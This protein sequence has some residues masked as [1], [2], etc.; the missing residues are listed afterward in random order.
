[1]SQIEQLLKYQQEDEKL[2]KLEHETANSEERKRFVQ[3][4][5]FLTKA[6]EQL[7]RLETK[8]ADL[9]SLLG[10]LNKSSADLEEALK[11]FENLDEMVEEGANVSF[12]KKSAVALQEKL[13]AVKSEIAVLSKSVKDVDDEYKA[14]KKKVIAMQRQYKES[15][16]QYRKLKDSKKEEVSAIEKDLAEISKGISADVLSKY[17]AKR[18]DRI[19]PIICAVKGDRCS[20]CGMELS[21][22]GKES[23]ASG[24]VV[25]CENCHR[26]LYK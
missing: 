6:P 22:K 8:A 25:E 5:N 15:Q 24:A 18:N 13:R 2:L 23:L 3:S 4:K 21:I 26:F 12:Y 17:K 19:F 14:L 20:K 1:M 16:E 10:K 11:D 7:D 9:I